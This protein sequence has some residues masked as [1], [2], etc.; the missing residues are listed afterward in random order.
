MIRDCTVMR[1]ATVLNVTDGGKDTTE[2]QTDTYYEQLL[3]KDI[4]IQ[5]LRMKSATKP[6][7]LHFSLYRKCVFFDVEFELHISYLLD[8]NINIY[9][10]CLK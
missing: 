3:T 5:N 4:K 2:L 10:T 9:N 1:S 8:Q 7:Q 6:T